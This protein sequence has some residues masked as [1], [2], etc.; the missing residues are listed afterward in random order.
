MEE[1]IDATLRRMDL[2]IDETI[3]SQPQL[4]IISVSVAA[5]VLGLL[6]KLFRI[7]GL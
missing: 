1:R 5:M 7:G 2:R 4:W 6:V 3:K